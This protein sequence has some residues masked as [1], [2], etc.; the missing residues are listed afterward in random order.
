M[1]PTG[2]VSVEA[3]VYLDARPTAS[4]S[5]VAAKKASYGLLIDAQGQ[6]EF[7]IFRPSYLGS[8]SGATRLR[9]GQWY[10][11]VGTYDGTTAR[12]CIDGV[13]VAMSTGSS[14][15]ADNANALTIGGPAGD[16][17]FNGRIDEVAVYGRS[18]SAGRVQAYRTAAT[19]GP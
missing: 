18:H 5:R 15:I 6:I 10:H 14:G 17:P 13:Q 16:L 7:A 9:L 19:V 8:L 4:N 3:W 2:A 12:L 1:S 11:L